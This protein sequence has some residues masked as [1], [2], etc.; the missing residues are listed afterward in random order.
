MNNLLNYFMKRMDRESDVVSTSSEGGPVITLSRQ[1]GCPGKSIANLLRERILLDKNKEWTMISKEILETLAGELN[2]NPSVVQDLAN[3][4]DRRITDYIALLLS[5]DYYPGEQKIKST[6][7]DIIL[8]FAQQGHTIIVGR[9]GFHICN[10]IRK[11]YHIRLFAPLEW[12]IDHICERRGLSYPDA[13]KQ[14]EEM[15]RRRDQFLKFFT[16][17][18][19]HDV[20]F[21]TSYDCSL[22]SNDE[23]VDRLLVG[24]ENREMI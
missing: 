11:S 19:K 20:A 2:L 3:F 14:V 12:R 4:E 9:A 6:L 17:T 15:S 10:Q 7:S 18:Q 23:I 8:S 13:M 21:D 24:L 1:Y 22:L 16:D 5:K